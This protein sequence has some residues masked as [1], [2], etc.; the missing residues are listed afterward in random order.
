MLSEQF[1]DIIDKELDV[2]IAENQQDIE[3]KK[4]KQ[5]NQQKGYAFLI[6]FLKMY[7]PHKI[8]F[9]D[10]ITDGTD[11]SSC[12]IIFS[13][14]ENGEEIFYVVQ[15]KWNIK[16]K[17]IEGK[18][19]PSINS[20]EVKKAILDFESL[21]RRDKPE[22]ANA[23]FNQKLVELHKHRVEN[24]GAVKFIFLA[25][26]PHN[27]QVNEHIRNFEANY[28]PC[29]LAIIDIER[30]KRDY[31]EFKYKQIAVENPLSYQHFQASED[32]II[33]PIERIEN[34]MGKGD[35]LKIEHPY[36]SYI[37]II[38][39]KT[40]FELFEK[41]K[42]A[43]FI[44]N[45]R[46][47]LPESNYNQ[48]I[49]QTL[50]RKPEMFWYYNNGITAISKLI[51]PVG[52]DSQIAE[53]RGLQII[54]GAQTV[55]SVYAAYKNASEAQREI[56][57]SDAKI[58]LRLIRSSNDDMNLEIT[59][60]TNSQ[61]PM[62]DRDFW[63]NDAVQI[64]L[65]EESFQTKYWYAKR[66]GEFRVVPDGVK[67]IDNEEFA[68]YYYY[69]YIGNAESL[70]YE[71]HKIFISQKENKEG[72][73]EEIFNK[74]THFEDMLSAFFMSEAC[75]KYAGEYYDLVPL[76]PSKE[77]LLPLS[78]IIFEKYIGMKYNPNVNMNRQVKKY[79]EQHFDFLL[80]KIFRFTH[81]SF[82]LF[83]FQASKMGDTPTFI[84]VKRE[85]GKINFTIQDI[86]NLENTNF[87][88][89]FK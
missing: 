38:K 67:V 69:F 4:L 68:K 8:R 3:N 28:P 48:A 42:F 11:D 16:P 12:D 52:F 64:R 6:W 2:I 60:Y 81:I 22:G 10:Y 19:P 63:A 24:G 49:V 58:S 89:T 27:A 30:L 34:A 29:K 46:N 51:K 86:E 1:Y 20:D 57:D 76:M 5:A 88:I 53:L 35:Y 62:E 83:M 23:L 50:Q 41:Y 72:I 71:P 7:S 43:L 39:P 40:I 75:E 84:E 15:S 59:R 55:Y 80:K 79:F 82:D 85:F 56:M 54:N 14:K 26:L 33:L 74:D 45:V 31:I 65:Q 44:A 21:F 78:K 25:L 73:Y 36:Q 47:P 32:K 37:F 77:V 9:K 87:G 66:R 17:N 13:A 18:Q 61:N 70:E